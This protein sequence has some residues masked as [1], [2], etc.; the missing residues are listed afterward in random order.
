MYKV[1]VIT[2][3]YNVERF[4]EKCARSLMEQTLDSIQYIFVDDYS[5]DNSI[6]VLNDVISEYPDR[7]KDIIIV[8]HEKNRGLSATRNTG[9]ALATGEYV[10]FCDSDDWVD[11][12]MYEKLYTEAVKADN[13]VVC[14][15]Y[16][17]EYANSRVVYKQPYSC[18]NDYVR[19]LLDGRMHNSLC[20]KLMKKKLY[21]N[22]D[23]LWIEGLNMW[24]DVSI[25]PRLF[26]Y[27]KRFSYISEPLYHYNQLNDNSYT[28]KIGKKSIDN[29][30][31]VVNVISDFFASKKGYEKDIIN[32]KLH[33]K[34]ALLKDT[35]KEYR[36]EL[37]DL[38]K[39][40][41]GYINQQPHFKQTDRLQMWCWI[42]SIDW[43]PSF[44]QWSKYIVKRMIR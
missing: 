32:F 12:D 18:N 31:E 29:I 27:V 39:E 43:V 6:S 10:I 16:Y 15:D 2:P 13:D 37:R 28:K 4:I 20:I 14:C 44:I 30:L 1:S 36:N 42:N 21:D 41:D 26:Y 8:N 25:V 17:G 7:K 19:L 24:E 5:K 33:T 22:L 9:I 3:V 38:Y 23:F 34:L 11:S 35:D 40:T